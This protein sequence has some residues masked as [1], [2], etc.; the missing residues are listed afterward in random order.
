[1]AR[2]AAQVHVGD[3]VLRFQGRLQPLE[4]ALVV[5][6]SRQ[7]ALQ[8]QLERGA[9]PFRRTVGRRTDDALGVGMS[10]VVM[11][12][13][14]AMGA[15]GAVHVGLTVRMRV[16]VVMTVM[17]MAVV[18]MPVVV[19]APRAVDVALHGVAA[20]LRL[21]EALDVQRAEPRPALLLLRHGFFFLSP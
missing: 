19:V 3:A 7:R 20:G 10:M 18:V 15:G 21:L 5:R 14:V 12:V 6:L 9:A 17:V 11:P 8:I 4:A 1:M 16:P 2:V 13:V